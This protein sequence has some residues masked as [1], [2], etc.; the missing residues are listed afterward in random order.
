[1]RMI[2]TQI[3]GIKKCPVCCLFR[4]NFPLIFVLPIGGLVHCWLMLSIRK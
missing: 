4:L 3:A 2:P 1:M